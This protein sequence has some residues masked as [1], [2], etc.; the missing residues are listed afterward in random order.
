MSKQNSSKKRTSH[1][2]NVTHVVDKHVISIQI[3]IVELGQADV[4]LKDRLGNVMLG[5]Q[6]TLQLAQ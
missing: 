1:V 3:P 4:T 2:L 5:G 6:M